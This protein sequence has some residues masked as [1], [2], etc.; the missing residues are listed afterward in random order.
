MNKNLSI[1]LFL[2]VCGCANLIP[3]FDQN[4]Y[5]SAT[6]LKAKSITLLS[7]ANE[8]FVNYQNDVADLQARLSGELAYE[9]G[10]SH[11]EVSSEQWKILSDP[12]QDLL[13]K[14]LLEWSQGKHFTKDYL[15]EKTD[16]IAQGFDQI[17][18]LEGS[19]EAQ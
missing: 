16:Q 10:K 11:N 1:V 3:N 17:L 6:A 2:M 15:R 4:S 12:T 18:R 14:M 8:P 13:G 19:K 5:D 9:Q 7:H